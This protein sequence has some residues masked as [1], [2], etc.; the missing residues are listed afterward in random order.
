VADTALAAEWSLAD[1]TAAGWRRVTP[2]SDGELADALRAGIA[3]HVPLPI[4]DRSVS[5]DLVPLERPPAGAEPAWGPVHALRGTHRFEFVAPEGARVLSLKFQTARGRPDTCDRLRLE[6]VTGTKLVDLEIPSDAQWRDVE[7]PLP[8]DGQYRLE[9]G[10]GS[11]RI[12]AP[13]GWPFVAV[14]R[15]APRLPSPGLGVFVPAGTTSFGLHYEGTAPLVVRGPDGAVRRPEAGDRTVAFAVPPGL[16]GA[17]WRL[18]GMATV[19]AVRVVGLPSVFALAPGG[20]MVPA[21]VAPT[22]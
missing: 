4:A 6:T 8:G 12:Q 9:A 1:P 11:F 19:P 13:A 22:P 15:V 3:D 17:V 2:V 16:D 20:M 10:P 7:L 14:G 5:A 18:E 21:E